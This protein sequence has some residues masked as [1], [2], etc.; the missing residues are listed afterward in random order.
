MVHP[1]N[2]GQSINPIVVAFST[3][4]SKC[5]YDSFE[6]HFGPAIGMGPVNLDEGLTKAKPGSH[7]TPPL[8]IEFGPNITCDDRGNPKNCPAALEQKVCGLFFRQTGLLAGVSDPA[9]TVAI[10][11][12]KEGI[13]RLPLPIG[14]REAE[15]I[16]RHT[17]HN[18]WWDGSVVDGAVPRSIELCATLAHNALPPDFPRL[19]KQADSRREN[20]SPGKFGDQFFHTRLP[21]TLV[22]GNGN[23][24]HPFLGHTDEV[25]LQ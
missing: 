6:R 16:H 25:A 10:H 19:F 15:I 13:I 9:P 21:G 3:H 14:S 17:R 18:V 20:I 11:A 1:H 24:S 22:G 8:A 2:T 5:I 23:L 7:C 4:F 12:Q